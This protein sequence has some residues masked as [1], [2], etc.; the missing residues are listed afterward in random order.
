MLLLRLR[1]LAGLLALLLLLL[2][3]TRPLRKLIWRAVGLL[4][5]V[6]R[7][8]LLVLSLLIRRRPTA[9]HRLLHHRSHVLHLK[10]FEGLLVD[11]LE[12]RRNVVER[13]LTFELDA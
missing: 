5:S 11:E 7:R 2:L 12:V 6:V 4:K 3:L 8:L 9:A 13:T 10:T 1:E